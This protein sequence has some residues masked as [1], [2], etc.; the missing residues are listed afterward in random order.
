[1]LVHE[2]KEFGFLLGLMNLKALF[3]FFFLTFIKAKQKKL[4]TLRF[5]FHKEAAIKKI[6]LKPKTLGF[7]FFFGLELSKLNLT[8]L[9]QVFI[10]KIYIL[11]QLCQF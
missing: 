9:H 7:F 10:Y 11:P 3:F 4:H 1:M 8:P 6:S 2:Y 5:I